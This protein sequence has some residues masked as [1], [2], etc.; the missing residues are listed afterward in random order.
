MKQLFILCLSLLTGISAFG[1]TKTVTNSDLEKFRQQRVE[2]ERKLRT[3]Y[4]K[5]GL[6]SPAEI[7]RRTRQSRAEFEQYSDQLR[8]RRVQSQNDLITQA[9]NLSIQIA[10]IDAQINYLRRQNTNNYSNQNYI[11]SYGYAP[12]GYPRNRS[13]LPQIVRLPQNARTVQEYASMY[14]SSQSIY[15]QATGNVRIGGNNRGYNNNRG[16]GGYFAPVIVGGNYESNN[17]SPQ[18][19]YLEQQRATL[20]AQWQN[21]ANQ[22]RQAGIRI[23]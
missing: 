23:D 6:P 8:Q 1:Q 9:N 2:S 3:D 12:Y 21:L 15:N 18:L 4:A 13:V 11:Y 7:E 10:S 22:A 16:Y 5:M 17:I 14:P 19:I 20:F